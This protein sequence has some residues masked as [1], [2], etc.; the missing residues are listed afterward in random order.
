MK[1]ILLCLLFACLCMNNSYAERPL[2]DGTVCE[3]YPDGGDVEQ[4]LCLQN[5]SATT[6][7]QKWKGQKADCNAINATTGKCFKQKNRAGQDV[8]SCAAK[9]CNS[10]SALWLHKKSNG[11]YESYGVC[12]KKDWLQNKYCNRG[13]AE[14]ASCNGECKLNVIQW[15]NP[16]FGVTNAFYNDKLCTCVASAVEKCTFTFTGNV[17]CYTTGEQY[18]ETQTLEIDKSLFD[19]GVCPE[20]SI[21]LQFNEWYNANRTKLLNWFNANCPQTPQISGGGNNNTELQN[22]RTKMDK[23]FE[24]AS[25]A[26]KDVWKTA[27]GKFNTARLASDLTAGVVLGTVGGV[28]SGVVIKK[29]QVEKG[30][31]A[32][33]CTVG[34]Q[35][36]ADWGDEFTVGL[37]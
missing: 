37:R 17:K 25:S 7:D 9:I 20:N 13:Q 28:V 19:G 3:T 23:F 15:Q 22:A 11:T 5:A 26:K 36:V 31:D 30:F 8:R 16:G 32:L 14:C 1:K 24:D 12:Y 35:T 2:C 18:T 33:H 29:K 27:D 4:T 6:F 21:N 34:G 10:D